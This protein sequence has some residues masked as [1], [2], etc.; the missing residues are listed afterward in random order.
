MA[1]GRPVRAGEDGWVL[2]GQL[3]QD[4]IA[5]GDL[6]LSR[7]LLMNDAVYPWLILVPRRA[8]LT[9]IIELDEAGRAALMEEIACASGALQR[10]TR[11]DKLN[12]AA[13]GNA[14]PQ[15]H[16]HVIARFRTD[17]A[18]PRPV[19]GHAAARPYAAD[20]AERFA[21]QLRAAIGL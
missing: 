14:V 16:V 2:H 20:E 6:P 9:E 18:W 3:A 1:I 12:V 8:G 13:L 19:W 7:V 10:V 4:C 15:L 21:A 11:C 5:L 17:P